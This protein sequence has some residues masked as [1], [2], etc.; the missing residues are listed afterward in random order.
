MTSRRSPIVTQISRV[1]GPGL[2]TGAADDDP[3]GIATYSQT[4][5][6]L[7]FMLCW[8]M[9]LTTPFMVAIQIVSAR[10]GAVTGR[11][12]AANLRQAL[13]PVLLY[14]VVVLF[15]L[16]NIFNIAADIAAMGEAV[17]LLVGGPAKIY[18]LAL[19]VLCL[20]VQI[21]LPYRPYARYMKLLTLVLFA[22]V[23][24]AF[25]VEIP[26]DRVLISTF[27]PR[28][29]WDH[30]TILLLVA[31]LG[32]TISPYLFFWQ[33]SLEM[34]ERRVTER[35]KEAP[36]QNGTAAVRK[37]FEPIVIDTWAG[38][39]LSNIVGFFII[40][41]TAATLHANGSAQINTAADAAEALRPLAGQF[42]FLLFSL[43]ILGT[44]LL[45]IPALAG[46]V[47][48]A[49]AE[50]F[51]WKNSLGMR[52]RR[53]RGFYLIIGGATLIGG[54]G[55]MIP[56]NPITMLVWSAVFNGIVAVPLMVGIMLI[57][58]NNAI[59]GKFAASRTLAIFGWLATLLMVAVVVAFFFTSVTG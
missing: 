27:M 43:G 9:F 23:A 24:T 42:A 10:V 56:I 18:A 15:A 29:S 7:G 44:G 31:V 57:V 33:A 55:A 45:A 5:A 54:L 35:K 13:P 59:M 49:G 12:L 26:W 47:A 41:T 34:E 3:S 36:L 38:M 40:V 53:A 28:V 4:G 11:G 25:S 37:R 39:A 8:T 30:D 32:T 17:R 50:I 20:A 14:G 21:F 22:Y 48:Y 51:G 19:A 1:L 52:P 46:S 58:T 16:A 6:Q 2:L